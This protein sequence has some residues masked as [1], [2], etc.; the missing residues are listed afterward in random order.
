MQSNMN[1][2]FHLSIVIDGQMHVY[3]VLHYH[4]QQWSSLNE[5]EGAPV[6]KCFVLC[7][8]SVRSGSHVS[9]SV[10][11]KSD[12]SKDDPLNF[13][14]E[15]ASRTKRY[16]MC[17]LFL[18]THRLCQKVCQWIIIIKLIVHKFITVLFVSLIKIVTRY[19]GHIF[20]S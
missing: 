13:S 19:F 9:S 2:S 17:F 11:V 3:T 7:V 1:M 6:V 15:T 16:L 4:P 20:F 18:F 12:R 14:E 5:T 8:I 10:S